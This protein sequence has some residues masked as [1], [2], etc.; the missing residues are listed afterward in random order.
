MPG[1]NPEAA[2]YAEALLTLA[3]AAGVLPRVEQDLA[4]AL[5]LIERSGDIRRFLADPAILGAGKA[6]AIGEI[7]KGK[8][9]PVFLHFLQILQETGRI[10]ELRAIA[11]AFF[12]QASQLTRKTTGELV[13]AQPL[14]GETVGRIEEEVSRL[15]GRELHLR[16]RVDPDLLGGVL[17]RVGD[18]VLDGTIDHYLES[19]GRRLLS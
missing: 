8:V 4:A 16:T 3:G 1:V 19:V 14:A 5:D 12:E 9:H 11:D 13:A 15:L 2:R 18:V 17:V 7:L 10:A 6:Q